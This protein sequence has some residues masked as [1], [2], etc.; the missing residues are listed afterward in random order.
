MVRAC[1]GPCRAVACPCASG[2]PAPK[3]PHRS[4][5]PWAPNP[6]FNSPLLL[7]ATFMIIILPTAPRGHQ[8]GLQES[9]RSRA[10]QT[11]GHGGCL[12]APRPPGSIFGNKFHSHF[13]GTGR[14]VPGSGGAG[15]IEETPSLLPPHSGKPPPSTVWRVS[16]IALA[17]SDARAITARSVRLSHTRVHGNP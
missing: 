13:L 6:V 4:D 11:G 7:L 10:V 17:L 14:K 3:H 12:Q 16:S 1:V 15:V 8:A 2:Q 5:V 9:S